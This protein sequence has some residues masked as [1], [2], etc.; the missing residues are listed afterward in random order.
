VIRYAAVACVLSTVFAGRLALAGGA[1]T[2]IASAGLSGQD[3]NVAI[4]SLTQ[5]PV[6]AAGPVQ[7]V[8][9]G[10]VVRLDASGSSD[11]QGLVPLTY[12]W[13]FASRPSG[14]AASLSNAK[15]VNATFTPDVLGDYVLSLVVTDTAGLESAPATV[16][17]S[18]TSSPPIAGAGPDQAIISDGATAV[19]H[20]SLSYDWE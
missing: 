12:A 8:R 7:T 19:L 3:H 11:P 1:G 20:E 5:P 6:A 17:V 4:G 2:V 14:S 15:S 13:S 9:V 18:T 10:S 16:L